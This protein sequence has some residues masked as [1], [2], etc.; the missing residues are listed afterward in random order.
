MI[1]VGTTYRNMESRESCRTTYM[2]RI[3]ESERRPFFK[4]LDGILAYTIHTNQMKL[5]QKSRNG[6]KKFQA[7]VLKALAESY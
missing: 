6:N 3:K 7:S 2:M 4:F 5:C 1:L